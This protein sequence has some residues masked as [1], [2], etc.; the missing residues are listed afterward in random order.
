MTEPPKPESDDDGTPEEQ[1][2]LAT[3]ASALAAISIAP[4]QPGFKERVTPKKLPEDVFLYKCECGN[5]HF[6]HAGY[7]EVM[8]PFM[9]PGSEKR[10][11]MDATQVMICVNCKKG[12]IWLNEQL[13]DVTEHI[14]LSAWERTEREA[15]H[16]TGPGGQ[17]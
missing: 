11:I 5:I 16:A 7:V 17:C 10:M 8:L 14:D 6:R 1:L 9:R 15:Q 12:Y 3:L 13:Y 2:E 4:D